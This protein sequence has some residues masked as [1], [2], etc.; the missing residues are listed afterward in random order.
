MN[1][2]TTSFVIF[3]LPVLCIGWGLRRNYR[4]YT[5]FLLAANILFYA[6]AGVSNLPFLFFIAL[7]NWWC[8]RAMEGKGR[9]K[10]LILVSVTVAVHVLI[11]AFFKYYEA[12]ALEIVELAGPGMQWLSNPYLASWVLPMGLSFYSF[13]GL[14]YTIDHYREDGLAPKSYAEVLCFLSFFPTVM[15][16]P[17]MRENH[18]FP[19][20]R[21]SFA[22]EE[23]FPEGVTLIVSGLFKKVVI[24]TYLQNHLVDAV[25][26]APGEYSSAAALMAV[27]AYSVQ[28][29]CDFSG[30]TNI[31][32]G[33]AQLMGFHIPKNFDDPY[34]SLSLQEFWHRWHISLS[35]WLRD[36]L[37]IPLGG[38]RKG[39]RYVNLMITMILGGIWHGSS[40]GFLVWGA[41]HGLGLVV[42]HAW[43][44]LTA[45]WQVSSRLL[46]GAGN[47][48]SWIVTFH[49]AAILWVYFR[50][51][52]LADAHAVLGRVLAWEQDGAGFPLAVL[53][54]TLWGVAL[55]FCGTRLYRLAVRGMSVL[56]WPVQ[57]LVAGALV[58]LMMNFGPDGVLPFIYTRF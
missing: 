21:T 36:Y 9:R 50:A 14:S 8:V 12:A 10:R 44:R 53:I 42:V 43:H 7:M 48:A 25:Y 23:D 47:L 28:I 5:L 46:R 15:S 13:Q 18:F 54:A 2:V 33:V 20:L 4:A 38:S 11:L 45:G 22:G 49:A 29:Y 32:M 39:N 37:Y 58:A 16:G 31:A 1:F 19:Q 35:T 56:P 30:Y 51:E 52:S 55:S 3:L 27:Y 34:R 57:G 24:A 17:I 41:L 6:L 26:A 40:L